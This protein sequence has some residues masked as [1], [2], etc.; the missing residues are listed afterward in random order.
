MSQ[1]FDRHALG[2]NTSKRLYQN[3]ASRT[4]WKNVARPLARGGIRL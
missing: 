1:H 4:H 3:T 2:M